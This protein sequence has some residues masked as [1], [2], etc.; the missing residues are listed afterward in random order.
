MD[1]ADSANDQG[2][3]DMLLSIMG[4]LQ[5]HVWMLNAYMG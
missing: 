4:G 2:T 1:I 5:K 3:S